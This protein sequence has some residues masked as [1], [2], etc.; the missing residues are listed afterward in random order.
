MTRIE[1]C[2]AAAKDNRDGV[3]LSVSG[4]RGAFHVKIGAAMFATVT[5]AGRRERE[6]E[7]FA[8]K[9]ESNVDR[10]GGG[11]ERF[12]FVGTPEETAAWVNGG[13]E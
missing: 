4:G 13:M 12:W 11:A 10:H 7:R 9:L 8:D 6:I 2:A 3:M 5:D 1:A